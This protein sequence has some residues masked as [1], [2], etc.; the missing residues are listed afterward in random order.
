MDEKKSVVDLTGAYETAATIESGE[1]FPL[2][3]GLRVLVSR[4]GSPEF[5]KVA[6]AASKKFAK[7]R[8]KEV[9]PEKNLESL[10]W[11]MARANFKG[12]T[13]LKGNP[14]VVSIEGKEYEDT[15]QGREGLLMVWPD[16]RDELMAL[17]GSTREEFQLEIDEAGKD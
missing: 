13:D 17:A 2:D 14:V 6:A 5:Y 4:G 15:K 1:W 12:F 3:C 9:P 10:I 11:V 16:F 8:G 7:G